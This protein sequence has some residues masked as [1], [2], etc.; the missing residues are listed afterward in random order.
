[1]LNDRPNFWL[2]GNDHNS[3][4]YNCDNN[5]VLSNSMSFQNGQSRGICH[6]E[7][8]QW[9]NLPSD[10][11]YGRGFWGEFYYKSYG[12]MTAEQARVQCESDGASLPVPRSSMENDFYA[13][14]YPDG[15]V[16]LG[17]TVTHDGTTVTTNT[18]DGSAAM[19]TAWGPDFQYAENTSSQGAYAY[20]DTRNVFYSN[21][22]WNVN[23]LESDLNYW[24]NNKTDSDLANAVCVYKI[25]GLFNYVITDILT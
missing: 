9:I 17:L 14:L 5:E 24:N 11:T 4:D 10:Y 3:A 6:T 1:M 21:V 20:I 8:H 23:L 16:W 12:E 13:E 19:Y 18:L 7:F 22:Y 2:D 15:T 25:P